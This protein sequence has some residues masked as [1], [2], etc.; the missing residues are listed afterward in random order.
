VLLGY[1]SI[2]Q[3]HDRPEEDEDIITQEPTKKKAFAM[4]ELIHNLNILVDMAEE[5][6]ILNDRK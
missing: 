4:P 3:R 1:H 6:I 2:S 5:E